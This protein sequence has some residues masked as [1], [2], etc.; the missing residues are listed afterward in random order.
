MKWNSHEKT[1]R[2]LNCV[3][4]SEKGQ[5]GK[6]TSQVFPTMRNSR[7]SKL[8]RKLNMWFSGLVWGKG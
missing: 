2:K 1:W 7:K 5:S 8:W 4:L 3:F 6:S